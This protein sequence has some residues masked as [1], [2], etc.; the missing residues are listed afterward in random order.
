MGL[1]L[2]LDRVLD[3]HVVRQ[4]PRHELAGHLFQHLLVEVSLL[5]CLVELNKLHDVSHS[6]WNRMRVPVQLRHLFEIFVVAHTHDN[7]RAWHVTHLR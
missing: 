5:S 3:W 6:A 2:W 7:H 1:N 4:H